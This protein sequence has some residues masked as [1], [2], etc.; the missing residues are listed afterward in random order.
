MTIKWTEIDD[1]QERMTDDHI[2]QVKDE[3]AIIY[4][5]E[6]CPVTVSSERIWDYKTSAVHYDCV[7]KAEVD[8][9]GFDIIFPKGQEDGW[10]L[11]TPWYE[12]SD[13]WGVEAKLM[14][15]VPRPHW[16]DE[17]S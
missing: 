13:S 15:P 10:Y 5:P 8:T 3:E 11:L 1:P 12:A 14:V 2:L 9:V 7:V 16:M 6:F 17:A 4:H